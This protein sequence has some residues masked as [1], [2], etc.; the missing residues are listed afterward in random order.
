M[1]FKTTEWWP[2]FCVC[3]L[4]TFKDFS[5]KNEILKSFQI[6]HDIITNSPHPAALQKAQNFYLI[7]SPASL[8]LVSK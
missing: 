4:K 6:F 5:N 8:L 3:Q 2:N 7:N 1:K